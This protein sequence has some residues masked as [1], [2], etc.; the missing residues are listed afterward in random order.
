MRA[1][2]IPAG[3]VELAAYTWCS[4]T[5]T[6]SK[7]LGFTNVSPGLRR[8]VGWLDGLDPMH[9]RVLE[10]AGAQE[11]DQFPSW[12]R[13]VSVGQF[14]IG[15]LNVIYIKQ[16]SAGVDD[17]GRNRPLI[18]LLIGHSS[19]LH[20]GMLDLGQAQMLLNVVA[21]P[22]ILQ[23]LSVNYLRGPNFAHDC[24]SH[25]DQHSLLLAELRDHNGTLRIR[26]ADLN[27]AK[28]FTACVLAGLPA[29]LWPDLQLDWYTG[30]AGPVSVVSLLD[31]PRSIAH[32]PLDE[33]I[34][35]ESCSHHRRI[36]TVW[37]SLPAARRNWRELAE[38]LTRPVPP[39]AAGTGTR[40]IARVTPPV[41]GATPAHI[42]VAGALQL[43]RW[44]QE[45]RLED[46]QIGPVVQ[47]LQ[48]DS[49]T[50]GRW[51]SM[52]SA[53]EL[54]ALLANA[55]QHSTFARINRSTTPASISTPVLLDTYKNTGLA[56]LGHVL[57]HRET[58]PQRTGKWA[59][60]RQPNRIQLTRLMQTQREGGEPEQMLI[61][62]LQ[63]GWAHSAENRRRYLA[64][65]NATNPTPT[66]RW[67]T[68]TLL[69]QSQLPEQT[70]AA[71]IREHPNLFIRSW[72]VTDQLNGALKLAVAR[73]KLP[74]IGR[75]IR[76]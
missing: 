74:A 11:P 58:D 16:V 54:H 1:P 23:S 61:A 18:L 67:V 19:E 71:F 22:G 46:R 36:E 52:L 55:E 10:T 30:A 49:A 32:A 7:G 63:G 24:A 38:A 40:P 60:P 47:A 76:T 50:S 56:V 64:A 43:E 33:T 31:K 21:G 35:G 2:E 4:S 62:I 34:V 70:L 29:A 20:L 57:L 37:A 26:H 5:L 53:G 44:G 14:A 12:K 68:D 59:V 3:T 65:L 15:S 73:R 75:L 41:Y 66:A 6:G 17:H 9:L 39:L 42:R 45:R 69:A 13:Q 27:A 8:Y 28:S 72:G 25:N 48:E 51:L